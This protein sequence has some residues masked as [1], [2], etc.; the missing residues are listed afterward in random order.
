MSVVGR[1]SCCGVRELQYIE[2]DYRPL[3]SVRN[4]A[5]ALTH[6][7]HNGFAMVFFTDI[8]PLLKVD[9]TGYH[10]G[11]PR[12]YGPKLKEYI[13]KHQLGKVTE[14]D[15]VLNKNSLN[16]VK[17]W[18]WYLDRDAILEKTKMKRA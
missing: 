6:P 1:T 4:V 17:M 12:K 5:A 18:V 13:E 11:E 10:H 15:Y 9:E 3:Q 14:G 8:C 7:M 16:L 2:Q